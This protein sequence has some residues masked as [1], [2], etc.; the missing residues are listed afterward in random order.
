MKCDWYEQHWKAEDVELWRDGRPSP[1]LLG[2]VSACP[3]C[4][5]FVSAEL[6]L[7]VLLN[8]VAERT[9]AL[10]PNPEVK[11]NLLAEFRSIRAAQP[12]I[13]PRATMA[14]RLVWAV[15]AL[16]CL[17][18]GIAVLGNL[19]SKTPVATAQIQ[20]EKQTTQTSSAPN[21]E[22]TVV[23]VGSSAKQALPT[24]KRVPRREAARQSASANEFYPLV[25]CDS[26]ECKGPMIEVRVEMPAS[27]LVN[28]EGRRRTVMADLLVG[29][30]GTVRG[31]KLLQ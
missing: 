6:Q 28:R 3:V 4:D 2:H 22:K 12:V 30:D 21:G 27:P 26:L 5:R 10:E 18:V 1:A 31:V 19:R 16:V 11:C 13:R 17:G 9:Q 14:L 8:E 25:M 15:V 20:H 7:K 23:P 24:N 29:E